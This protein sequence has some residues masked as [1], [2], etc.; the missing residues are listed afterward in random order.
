[1]ARKV[2]L[3]LDTNETEGTHNYANTFPLA[4]APPCTNAKRR[5]SMLLVYIIVAS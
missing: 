3:V 2:M 4:E 1:M 5:D